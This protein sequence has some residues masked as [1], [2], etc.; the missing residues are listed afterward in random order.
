MADAVPAGARSTVLDQGPSSPGDVSPRAPEFPVVEQPH[1][2]VESGEDRLVLSYADRATESNIFDTC[3][4]LVR[5][6]VHI[7]VWTEM[8]CRVTATL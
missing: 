2:R 4:C 5:T 3:W 8:D 1:S 7:E 6:Y